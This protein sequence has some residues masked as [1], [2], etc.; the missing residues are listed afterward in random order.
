M[1]RIGAGKYRS[2]VIATPDYGT[3]PTKNMVRKAMMSMTQHY[4]EDANVLDLF[5]GSG[6]LG[7]EA[8]SLGATQAT[9]VDASTSAAKIIRDNL[10][11]LRETHGVVLCSDYRGA[12]ARMRGPFDLVFIDPPYE[13]KEAYQECLDALLAGNLLSPHCAVVLE[14]EGQLEL[15][16]DAFAS[17]RDYTYGKTKVILLQR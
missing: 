6:A 15:K 17:R 8:L 3:E 14:Y 4:L 13:M 2:R 1:I 16:H 5:A 11:L 9:F 7:I 12:F 10:A